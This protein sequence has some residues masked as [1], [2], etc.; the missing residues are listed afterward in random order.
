[1]QSGKDRENEDD[2]RRLEAK[3]RERGGWKSKGKVNEGEK[4]W[5]LFPLQRRYTLSRR[6]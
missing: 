2:Y 6:C 5:V 4:S 3:I 1:M